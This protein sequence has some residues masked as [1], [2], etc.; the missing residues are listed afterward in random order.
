[1]HSII[2]QYIASLIDQNILRIH[3]YTTTTTINSKVKQQIV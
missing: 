3:G 2:A 1:M